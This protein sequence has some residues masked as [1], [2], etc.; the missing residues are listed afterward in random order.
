MS[1]L[2]KPIWSSDFVAAQK[3]D[4]KSLE[5]KTETTAATTTNPVPALKLP[6]TEKNRFL[7][8][9]DLDD[10]EILYNANAKAPHIA[11]NLRG[12]F[13]FSQNGSHLSSRLAWRSPRNRR[14]WPKPT[15]DRLP[16]R[17]KFLQSG[18]ATQLRYRGDA[19]ERLPSNEER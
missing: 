7:V 11:E 14:Y 8:E 9:G 19:A 4:N 1:P 17:L 2:E 5:K 15:R 16:S 3:E 6:T 12:D 13:V 18:T 10:V